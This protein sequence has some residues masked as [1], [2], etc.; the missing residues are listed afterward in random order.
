MAV[1]DL[2]KVKI[3][4]KV[5]EFAHPLGFKIKLAYLPVSIEREISKSCIVPKYEKGK[6]V[7]DVDT[8][9]FYSLMA[10]KI[11]KGWSGLTFGMLKEL[12][13]IGNADEIELKDEDEIDFSIDSAILLLKENTDFDNWVQGHRG[14]LSYFNALEQAEKN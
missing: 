7:D 5:A 1:L 6:L 3:A 10:P 12:V 14:D 9:R 4:E 11:I 2:S 8:D 13:S